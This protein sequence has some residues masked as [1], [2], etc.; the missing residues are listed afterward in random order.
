M[1]RS[2][3]FSSAIALCLWTSAVSADPACTSI[4]Q[5]DDSIY[6]VCVGDD[7]KTYCQTCVHNV[8]STVQCN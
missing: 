4:Q 6:K 2:L 8:C 1:I 5:P 3:T 7:G